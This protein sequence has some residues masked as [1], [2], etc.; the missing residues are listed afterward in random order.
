MSQSR[1]CDEAA[2]SHINVLSSRGKCA[3]VFWQGEASRGAASQIQ[4]ALACLGICHAH[5]CSELK[6][7]LLVLHKK[8]NAGKEVCSPH[9]PSSPTCITVRC[10][11]G[12]EQRTRIE[13]LTVS[14]TFSSL[15]CMVLQFVFSCNDGKTR[16][17]C[18][19]YFVFFMLLHETDLTISVRKVDNFHRKILR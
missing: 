18:T 4:C 2:I 8:Q 10:C 13:K 1:A 5:V 16:N 14:F 9:P 7:C 12:R 11:V 3:T 6:T 19:A 15:M 17:V